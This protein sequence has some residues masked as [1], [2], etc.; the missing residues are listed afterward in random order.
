MGVRVSLV[1]VYI[2][3]VDGWAGVQGGFKWRLTPEG[4][5]GNRQELLSD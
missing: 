1:G 2:A 3:G 5:A 4:E